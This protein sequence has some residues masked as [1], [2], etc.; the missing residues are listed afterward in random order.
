MHLWDIYNIIPEE[1]VNYCKAIQK[2]GKVCNKGAKFYC[3]NKESEE[4]IYNCKKHCIHSKYKAIKKPK[5]V[6][7][8]LLQDLTKLIHIKLNEIYTNN[9]EMFHNLSHIFIELQPKINQRMKFVSHIIYGKFADLLC[10]NNTKIRF[11][12]ASKKLKLPYENREAIAEMFNE[13][14]LKDPYKRRK[15]KSV[16]YTNWLFENYISE[17]QKEKWYEF[18]SK[19]LKK[20]DLSDV[21]LYCIYLFYNK[22]V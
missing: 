14:K 7:S 3:E 20:D 1:E 11:I 10:N 15:W 12:S 9:E 5:K 17:E 22:K 13:C 6:S 4:L 21:F 16:T 18:Y 19:Q 8:Y 2:N